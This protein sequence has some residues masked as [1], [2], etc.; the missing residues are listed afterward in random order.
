MSSRAVAAGDTLELRY[1]LRPR[2]GD[3]LVSNFDDPE[4][5]TLTLGDGTLSPALEAW[6]IDL[7]P[8]ERHVFLLDPGQAFGQSDPGLIQTLAKTDLPPDMEF[9]RD[10]LVEFAMPGGQTLA[11]RILEVADDAIKVDFNHPLADLSIEFEVEVVRI[12]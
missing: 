6:L 1:A 12:L 11:G 3:D 9:V 4:A 7:T 5:E 8:G 2:G 10:H